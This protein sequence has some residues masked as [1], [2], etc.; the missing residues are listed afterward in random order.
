M[1]N[2]E[3]E[4]VTRTIAADLGLDVT[5]HAINAESSDKLGPQVRVRIFSKNPKATWGAVRK[6]GHVLSQQIPGK[7]YSD[8]NSHYLVREGVY[9]SSKGWIIGSTAD[10]RV[11]LTA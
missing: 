10:L 5:L 1:T 3:I 6:I 2:N 9:G 7:V 11:Y 8:K 4:N